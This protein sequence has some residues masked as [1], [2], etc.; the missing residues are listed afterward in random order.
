MSLPQSAISQ[1]RKLEKAS[2]SASEALMEHRWHWTL[3]ESNPKRVSI[4]EYARSVGK[5]PRLIGSYANGY[6]LL[7]EDGTVLSPAEALERSK[8]SEET[9]AATEAVAKA[10]GLQPGTVRQDRPVEI[11][12]VREIARERA[13]QHGTTVEAETR[14]AANWIVQS[15]Q[16]AQRESRDRKKRLGLRFVELEERLQRTKRELIQ[17]VNLASAVEW[18]DEERELL[19]TTLANVK[20]L[21]ELANL[22][23]VG[24]ADVDWDAELAELER[25]K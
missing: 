14:K 18:G 11:R 16:A 22:A 10:R 9:W 21:I 7:A 13:E 17:V 12:R 20:A 1:D 23:L 2:S 3:D 8:M 5:S 6:V 19:G 24:A 15:E 25:S 4:R